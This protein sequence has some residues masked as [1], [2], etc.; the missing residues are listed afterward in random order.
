[1]RRLE[2]Y[3]ERISSWIGSLSGSMA[4]KGHWYQ[5]GCCVAAGS[6]TDVSSLKKQSKSGWEWDD[7]KK[8]TKLLAIV[9]VPRDVVFPATASDAEWLPRL[10]FCFREW[11]R[12]EHGLEILA[13]AAESSAPSLEERLS[14]AQKELVRTISEAGG[15]RMTTPQ[16][17]A[18]LGRKGVAPS[19]GMT[20]Q[21]LAMLVKMGILDNSQDEKPPGYG[22]KCGDLLQ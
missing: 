11:P 16:V 19:D 14:E 12:I 22:I 6:S 15:V 10:P 4:V 9:A 3:D 17:L 1:M 5:T 13:N 2:Q 20:K 8:L 18:A 7:E 21:N